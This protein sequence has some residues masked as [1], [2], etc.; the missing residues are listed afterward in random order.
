MSLRLITPVLMLSSLVLI[1][2]GDEDTAGSPSSAVKE[3]EYPKE[4]RTSATKL[5]IRLTGVGTT[6]EATTKAL[7]D[8]FN[9]RISLADMIMRGGLPDDPSSLQ[10]N[11][12]GTSPEMLKAFA[13][14]GTFTVGEGVDSCGNP[15]VSTFVT[16]NV[17]QYAFSDGKAYE[18]VWPDACANDDDCDDFKQGVVEVQLTKPR[19]D[20]MVDIIMSVHQDVH[21][22]PPTPAMFGHFMGFLPTE[23]NPGFQQIPVFLNAKSANLMA[24][25]MLEFGWAQSGFF[26]PQSTYVFPHT[27]RAL[28]AKDISVS[29]MGHE[30]CDSLWT[31]FYSGEIPYGCDPEAGL[32]KPLQLEV[33]STMGEMLL[34]AVFADGE[35]PTYIDKLTDA[36][37]YSLAQ[38]MACPVGAEESW[39]RQ[40]P[41]EL[42]LCPSGEIRTCVARQD[43]EEAGCRA[44]SDAPAGE[45]QIGSARQTVPVLV[46]SGLPV[47]LVATDDEGGQMGPPYYAG[48]VGGTGE[49]L[50]VFADQG[51]T[52]VDSNG[53]DK[54][55]QMVTVLDNGHCTGSSIKRYDI[56]F[57]ATGNYA[58][59]FN[60]SSGGQVQIMATR[61]TFFLP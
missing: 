23:N 33:N 36:F 13:D 12:G 56:A 25:G 41:V 18:M 55:A 37:N 9:S 31:D 52:V 28:S 47:T 21:T 17:A 49:V 8:V 51:F 19:Y 22:D 50:T 39:I 20:G 44:T 30:L 40:G 32:T 42:F 24:S 7:N 34:S 29:L 45:V 53:N 38:T 5:A 35:D 57:S 11:I 4:F 6:D 1:S 27:E 43:M 61:P 2:C 54:T 59:A 58:L 60:L 10:G 48:V 14:H 26:G 46:P 3:I 15:V 16:P